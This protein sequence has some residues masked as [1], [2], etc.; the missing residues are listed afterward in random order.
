M[1]PNMF[2]SQI[3]KQFQAMEMKDYIET[4]EG[5]KKIA[6]SVSSQVFDTSISTSAS[7]HKGRGV[8]ISMKFEKPQDCKYGSIE[9]SYCH[10]AIVPYG[11]PPYKYKVQGNASS[12]SVQE[13]D[14]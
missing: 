6:F 14:F 7:C 1:D 8:S 11:Y 12:S 4:F 10:K 5:L 9:V 2:S 3:Q 13:Q